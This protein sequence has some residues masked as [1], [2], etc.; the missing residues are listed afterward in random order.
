[1]KDELKE[2][3]S[4]WGTYVAVIPFIVLLIY[5][6]IVV[7]SAVKGAVANSIGS[8]LSSKFLIFVVSA[9]V[10]IGLSALIARS[11]R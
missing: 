4:S 2:M 7:S 8:W 11:E 3:L 6:A 1:M 10:F 5:G 9:V